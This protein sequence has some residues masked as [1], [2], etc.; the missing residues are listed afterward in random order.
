LPTL[1]EIRTAIDN[2][3]QNKIPGLRGYGAVPGVDQLPA[4]VVMPA[5]DAADFTGAMNR[6]MDTWRFDL[7][8]LVQAGEIGTAQQQLD[9]FVSGSGDRS[10]RQCFYEDNT[11]GG[12]VDDAFCEAVRDYG[13][14]F[15]SARIDHVG[16]IVRLTVRAS[17][18]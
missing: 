10:V 8:I 6:G 11:L 5:R 2:T 4:M 18:K 13:G 7:Y 1:T 9:Q 15:Q 14:K 3:V 17:G 12:V 16:A